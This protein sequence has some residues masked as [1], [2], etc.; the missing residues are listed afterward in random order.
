MDG[1]DVD[2]DDVECCC[3]S[4]S[5]TFIR[6]QHEQ[7]TL[8]LNVT[9]LSGVMCLQIQMV[10]VIVLA[11]LKFCYIKIAGVDIVLMSFQSFEIR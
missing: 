4:I 5:S 9:I 2:V 7:N 3:R 8:H 11:K 6:K 10:M 1:D